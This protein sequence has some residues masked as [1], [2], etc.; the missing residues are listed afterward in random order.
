MG[1]INP[2]NTLTFR[3][4]SELFARILDKLASF[5][6]QNMIDVGSFYDHV[7]YILN[8]LGAA[9][10]RECEALVSV[11]NFRAKLPCNFKL[12]YAAYKCH[13]GHHGQGA[14]DINEQ[15]NFGQ[16]FM[17]TQ[18]VDLT[19]IC[20]PNCATNCN[21][22]QEKTRIVVRNF[23]NGHHNEF[24]YHNPL[25]LTL[26]PNVKD[27]CAPHCMKVV[28][29]GWNEV[30]IADG[31]I[32]TKFDKDCIYM[33]YY[34]LPIDDNFLPMIPDEESIEKAIEY[35]IYKMLFEEWYLNS[36][37]PNIVNQ[38]QY[39]TAEYDKYFSQARYWCRLP[40]FQ[41]CIQMVRVQRGNNKFYQF[42]VD[43]TRVG[44]NFYGYGGINNNRV[45]FGGGYWGGGGGNP[46]VDAF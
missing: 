28:H 26:S 38:L 41:K 8:Q 39:A 7:A 34:G 30:T 22:Q 44:S 9:V 42:N 2:E 32:R 24:H 23:V 1:V 14:P 27:H 40:S 36:S 10:Y 18:N 16:P 20:P 21:I 29:A 5:D 43:K 31:H 13:Q 4:T 33:Q 35:Y 19:S 11:H 15:N 25:P 45:G 37:V 17:F 12:W 3:P 6:S 46:S